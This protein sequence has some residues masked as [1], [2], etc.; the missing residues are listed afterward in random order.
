LALLGG[1][2]A[3]RVKNLTLKEIDQ[4]LGDFKME[5][6]QVGKDLIASKDKK[7]N[8][9]NAQNIVRRWSEP[10]LIRRFAVQPFHE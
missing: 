9:S 4:F 3:H 1:F 6:T 5:D 8:R 10:K 7:A 2:I